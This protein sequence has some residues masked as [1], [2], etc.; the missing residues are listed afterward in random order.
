M[1][2]FSIGVFFN[3][4]DRDIADWKEQARAIKK[5]G[6][7]EHVEVLLEDT[8]ITSK[9]QAFLKDLLSPYRIIVHAPFMDLTLLSP[10]KEITDSSI[11]IF[12]KALDIGEYLSAEV[13]TLHAGLHPNFWTSEQAK[14]QTSHLVKEL[15]KTTS[16]KLAVENMSLGGK[17]QIP[18]PATIA[19]ITELAS[20]LPPAGGVTIDIGHLLIDE[21]DVFDV[22]KKAK[23]KI[24]NFHLHDGHKGAAHLRLGDGDLNLKKFLF[25]LDEIQY[26]YFVTLEV[27]GRNEI[28]DSWKILQKNLPS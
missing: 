28:R 1:R 23:D 20:S 19:Q 26:K 14:N 2:K 17:T 8:S 25:L 24:Y 15:A 6:N 18:F 5:L 7:V 27:V 3:L 11:R 16:L 12:K 21:F 22:I 10:H 9:E 13:F 4:F